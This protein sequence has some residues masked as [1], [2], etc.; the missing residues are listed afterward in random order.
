MLGAKGACE[1]RRMVDQV[2]DNPPLKELYALILVDASLITCSF[3]QRWQHSAT[4]VLSLKRG[5]P[6]SPTCPTPTHALAAP[7]LP[8]A[9][10]IVHIHVCIHAGH[11]ILALLVASPATDGTFDLLWSHYLRYTLTRCR[12][13]NV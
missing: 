8:I 12:C 11:P 10:L 3:I 6:A 2:S 9:K 1:K 13:G 4:P 5:P 7:M